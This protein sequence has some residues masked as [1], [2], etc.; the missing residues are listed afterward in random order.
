MPGATRSFLLPVAMPCVPSSFL[1]LVEMPKLEMA[2]FRHHPP[3]VALVSLVLGSPSL[4][5]VSFSVGSLA[6]VA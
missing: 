4:Y 2:V 6:A 3:C 1:L 5:L